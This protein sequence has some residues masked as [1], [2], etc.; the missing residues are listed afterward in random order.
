LP[1]QE[2]WY[3]TYLTGQR[4]CLNL[5]ALKGNRTGVH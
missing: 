4:W 3:Y 2:K 5:M 1:K